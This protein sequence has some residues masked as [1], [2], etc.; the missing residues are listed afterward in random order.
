MQQADG[1]GPCDMRQ[2]Q[3]RSRYAISPPAL[4]TLPHLPSSRPCRYM[5]VVHTADRNVHS[6][7]EIIS[8]YGN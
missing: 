8:V 1:G 2:P 5:V 3:H 6:Q 4:L 7:G